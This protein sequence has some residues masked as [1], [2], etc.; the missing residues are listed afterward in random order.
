MPFNETDILTA[1]A[2]YIIECTRHASLKKY[3]ADIRDWGKKFGYSEKQ[4]H[5]IE[6][7]FAHYDDKGRREK[8]EEMARL[9]E[10]IGG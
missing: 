10:I 8:A 2:T 7:Q 1:K 9:R 4:E 6:R 5:I 3:I